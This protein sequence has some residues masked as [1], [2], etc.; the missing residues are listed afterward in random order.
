MTTP[1]TLSSR[2]VLSLLAVSLFIGCRPKPVVSEQPPTARVV[3]IASHETEAAVIASGAI[4]AVNK[5]A[6]AFLVAGRI[7]AL[8]A[9]DGQ[10]VEEGQVLAHLDDSDLR[11]QLAIAEARDNEVRQRYE[12]LVRLH[13]AGSLTATDFEK[14]SAARDE[15]ASALVLAQRQL[16]YATLRAPFAGRLVKH[17]VGA[18]TV[19]SPGAPVFTLIADSPVWAVVNLAEV[20]VPHVRAGTPA[21]VTLPSLGG[22]K[23]QGVVESISPQAEPLT[24]SF[25]ARIRFDNTEGRFRDGNVVTAKLSTQRSRAVISLAPTAIH[26]D[27]DGAL[28]VWTLAADRPVVSRRIVTTGAPLE[29]EVE[30]TS[31]L[32]PGDRVVVH[33]SA[34]LYEGQTVSPLAP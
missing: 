17:P 22:L 8:D 33:S 19:V 34:P 18:G 16:D 27:P 3:T 26:R 4:Q 29:S 6:V 30:I 9:E 24:R 31:G 25:A 20:D 12:R 15:A 10:L 11:K 28:Y 14:I 13:E 21:E 23:A 1:S 5:S 32:S 7:A 2:V